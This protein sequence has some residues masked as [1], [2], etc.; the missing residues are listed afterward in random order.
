[1]LIENSFRL[2]PQEKVDLADSSILKLNVSLTF[3]MPHPSL[4][5]TY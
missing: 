4:I 1:M 2:D 5:F 3:L